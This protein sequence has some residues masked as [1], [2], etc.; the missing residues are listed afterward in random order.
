MH[1]SILPSS[2]LEYRN[3]PFQEIVQF[4]KNYLVR[5]SAANSNAALALISLVLWF[6][7]N[8]EIVLRNWGWRRLF[9]KAR[10]DIS[11]LLGS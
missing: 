11:G 1:P 9:H 10:L 7:I 3:C 5:V 6:L 8:W 4:I 2:S